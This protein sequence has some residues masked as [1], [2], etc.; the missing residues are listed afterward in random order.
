[1]TA[2]TAIVT[3]TVNTPHFLAGYLEQFAERSHGEV[4]F[5]VVGDKRSP[6]DTREWLSKQEWGDAAWTY[7]D[8]QDQERWHER[9]PA[10]DRLLPWNTIQRRNLGYVCAAEQ[11]A[12][13][14]ITIDDDNF[15]TG[16]DFLAGHG[17]VGQRLTVDCVGS[18]D[19]WANVCAVLET[20]GG[21]VVH[22]GFPLSR[23]HSRARWQTVSRT[24][25]I[26]VNAGFWLGE[27]D[28]DAVSRIANP[29]QVLGVAPGTTTP[30]GLAKGT[31]C[32]FNSQNTAFAV[33]LLPAAYLVVMGAEYRGMR[34]DRY[35][36]IWMSY[37]VRAIADH[38]DDL[39]VYGRPLVHQE[40]NAHDLLGN[41]RGELPGMILT[42]S[43]VEVLRDVRFGSTTYA[44]CYRELIDALGVAFTRTGTADVDRR[45]W[46]DV[47]NSMAL[48]ADLCAQVLPA[49]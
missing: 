38:L 41:L 32:P 46:C 7:L 4:S 34:I 13:T 1:M 40:R 3:T 48:W 44:E 11:G 10:L 49:T 26:A 20:D 22:R 39:V 29:T 18:D 43:L 23:R 17:I 19:G 33:D 30:L 36:D 12:Q 28:V 45:F 27:P 42:D 9:F 14:I 21:P 35:D 37:F 15:V 6:P 25:R 8:V 16:D 24:G 2:S 5:V 31:W 47:L